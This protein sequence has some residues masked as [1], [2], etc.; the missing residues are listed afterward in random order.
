VRPTIL[1]TEIQTAVCADAGR[2]L[3][4]KHIAEG[5]GIGY[6]TLKRW[7]ADGKRGK[8]EPFQALW[9]GYT[10][11]RAADLAERLSRIDAAAKGGAVV[12]EVLRT[13]ARGNPILERTYSAPDWRADAWILERRYADHYYI[14]RKEIAELQ[15]RV[16][17]M[18]K[19][20][21]LRPPTPVNGD[22]PD[23]AAFWAALRRRQ[24]VSDLQADGGAEP[25]DSAAPPPEATDLPPGNGH[26]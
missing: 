9:A 23:P 17:A 6:S 19:A 16:K 12:R 14:D 22:E 24:D 11:A 1:T 18:E 20:A 26:A 2:G 15:R 13:A 25:V 5:L 8:G 10:Q 7:L 21:P 4:L 3:P